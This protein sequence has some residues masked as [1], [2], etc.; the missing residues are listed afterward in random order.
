M[1]SFIV[2]VYQAVKT[3]DGC[4][5]S[6]L[7]QTNTDYE[8]IL[9]DDGS[10]DGSGELCDSYTDRRIKVIHG[11]NA[12]AA[13]A[14]NTGLKAA[15]GDWIAFVDSDDAVSPGYLSTLLKAAA[16][17]GADI[18]SCAHVKCSRTDIY[19]TGAFFRAKENG[20]SKITVYRDDKGLKALLY[21]KGFISA[22][23]G[24]ISKKSL[25]E[26]ISFPEGTA[27]EDMGT[28]YR[29]FLKSSCVARTDDIL[30]GY[31]QSASNTI[32]STSAKRNPDYYNHSRQ[33]LVYIK[34]NHP[35]CIKAAASRHLSTCFQILSE[36]DP[37]NMD[38]KTRKLRDMVYADIKS[39]RRIVIRDHKA[40]YR[41]RVAAF[42]SYFGIAPIH[43]MLHKKYIKT[44]PSV[45]LQKV[46]MAEYQG[47]C[48]EDGKAVGHAP[49]VLTE[50][51]DLISDDH[52]VSVFAPRT[53]ADEI[54][55]HIR[56]KAEITVLPHLIV[57][58]AHNTLSEKVI[59]KFRM[60]A[61]IRSVLKKSD[62]DVIWFFNV[63]FYL[64]L[65][66]MICGNRHRK[67]VVTIFH[68][69]YHTGRLAKIKQKIFEEGQKKVYKCI[70]SG[71]DFHFKNMS[72]VFVPDYVCDD[73]T[74]AP[75]RKNTKEE[76][77]ACLGTMGEDKQLYELVEAFSRVSYGLLI[78]GRFYDRECYEDLRE[79]ASDNIEVRDEYLGTEEYL[80]LLSH[81]TYAVL[82][83][84]ERKYASQTS[85]V[86][87]EALFTDTIV[88]TH[89]DILKGNG[90]PGIGYSSYSDINDEI[91]M[92]GTNDNYDR[93]R[94][95]LSE[96]D[97]LRRDVYSRES[98]K[99]KIKNSLSV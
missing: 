45:K 67:I 26:D 59:N 77:V 70:S 12:G 63:E 34:N 55:E 85:G 79:N 74:Y 41:N 73:A 1:V 62:A 28:M 13:A 18:V 96:Y 60:F 66:L 84:N 47:R 51:F 10:T 17:T 30:Y 49:K 5:Q 54:P 44:I 90:I 92:Y 35:K 52:D 43:R 71:A 81:A 6:I 61:N 93:N 80:N 7:A 22:P 95:I 88:L 36:T 65:Y 68:D 4:V 82:P 42:L 50:Y 57:M 75:L 29:L 58:K 14:R 48:D 87:Q 19:D 39:V 38:E 20:R 69:G 16:D 31:V 97:R 83:Y 78:A 72:S 9:V 25:W 33:M 21:Q 99:E 3:L 56:K 37:H 40:R 11:K 53:I 91:L 27:A 23:W 94:A 24:M 46:C 64:F 76:Y 98:I 89:K 86:M 32:Y 15:K 8:L 2:P